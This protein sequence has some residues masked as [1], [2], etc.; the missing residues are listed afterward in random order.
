MNK[1]EFLQDLKIR[2]AKQEI[3]KKEIFDILNI[4]NYNIYRF[5]L[6]T[7]LYSIGII[8]VIIGLIVFLNRFWFDLPSLLRIFITL[9]LGM[10][11]TLNAIIF[12]KNKKDSLGLVFY[13]IGGIISFIGSLVL[14]YELNKNLVLNENHFL[15]PMIVFLIISLFYLGINYSMKQA[16]LS[17]FSIFNLTL[18]FLL[19]YYFV[20]DNNVDIIQ[21][22]LFIVFI[23]IG[24]VYIMLSK[25]FENTFN[26]HLITLTNIFGTVF[27]LAGSISKIENLL[28]QFL[29]VIISIGFYTL[30]LY[31]KSILIL[32]INT[33]FLAGYI[34]YITNKYFTSSLGW[35]V[36]LITLG[37]IFIGLGYFSINLNQRLNHNAEDLM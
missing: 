21:E 8:I 7:V 15:I 31:L 24:L 5:S 13:F 14:V 36:S 32:V 12:Q 1:I 25:Y 6:N 2:L 10:G 11:F 18:L 29:Y 19:L 35:S 22:T 4:R 34:I 28:W 37:L 26:K 16:V 23:I 9:G 30:S 17:F 33:L 20:L 27:I 3:S